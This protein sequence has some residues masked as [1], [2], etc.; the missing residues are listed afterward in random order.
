MSAAS[1][2]PVVAVVGG[3]L[4]GMAAALRCADAGAAVT[5][6]ESRPTLGGA[7]A[8]QRRDGLLLD[9]G[10]HVFL[11]CCAAY[12]EFLE[13]IGATSLTTLQERL[14]IDVVAS[15][16]RSARLRRVALP[17]PLHLGPALARY[18]PLARGERLAAARAALAARHL[19]PGD[20]ALDARTLGDWLTEHG[21]SERTVSRLWDLFV[22]SAL[23]LR[24][25][26]ASLALAAT[27]LR[28][29]LLD[30]AD[31]GDIGLARAPLSE[32]HDRCASTAL[33][34]AGVDVHLGA[35]VTAVVPEGDGWRVV[36][37]GGAFSADAVVL[38]VPAERVAALLPD[39]A[40][41]DPAVIAH[42][43]FSPIVNVHVIY[44]QAVTGLAMAAA[45]DS[46]VQWVFDRSQ[47][48]GVQGRQYLALS[49]SDAT[50]LIDRPVDELRATFLPALAELFPAAR[51]TAVSWFGVTRARHATFRQSPGSDRLRP[52]ATTGVQGL[53]LAGAWTDTGW[54]ATMEGAVRSGHTAAR[55]ALAGLV[56]GEPHSAVAEPT[57]GV[58]R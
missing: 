6:L 10:Q 52:G 3:G 24:A 18:R 30:R 14:E 40:L 38:A 32:L 43:G 12:R 31:A 51:Q 53:Y 46:P 34:A 2:R 49:L 21:Q 44:D 29:G 41:P 19:D 28:T 56:H 9:T 42:L 33:R 25:A 15:G 35:R 55:L 58:S 26:D 54:P 36:C 39:G 20:P 1:E 48:T 23:N 4:S 37:P 45:L 13:R 5:L 27:V 11:R 57:T 47:A 8:S 16:G 17:A 22:L 50:D 7:A